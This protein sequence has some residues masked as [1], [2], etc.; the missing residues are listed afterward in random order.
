[1][2]KGTLLLIVHRSTCCDKALPTSDRP[3]S[4]PRWTTFVHVSRYA[5]DGC[6]V[7]TVKLVACYCSESGSTGL[8]WRN[9]I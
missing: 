1:L 2:Q 5:H 3:A 8:W 6:W 9:S 4:I 7:I